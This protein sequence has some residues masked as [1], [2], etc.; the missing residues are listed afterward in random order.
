MNRLSMNTAALALMSFGTPAMA[1]AQDDSAPAPATPETAKP[2]TPGRAELVGLSAL[3]PD[4]TV[5]GV[6]QEVVRN[7]DDEP[8]HIVIKR[9]ND[10]DGA[11]NSGDAGGGPMAFSQADRD[12][13]ETGWDSSLGDWAEMVDD[14]IDD[15]GDEA[16]EELQEAWGEVEGA[17]AALKEETDETWH[18][19][20]AS[21]EAAFDAFE[22]EWASSVA[23]ESGN[24]T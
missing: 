19:T 8:V 11:M 10:A 17:W 18:R 23:S 13:Y 20:Q 22:R 7:D 3:R 2:V 24:A 21:F 16:T 9:S 5:A 1:V 14:R 12:N 15:L 6:V 4:G